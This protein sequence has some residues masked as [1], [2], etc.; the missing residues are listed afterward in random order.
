MD[1]LLARHLGLGRV[2]RPQHI[3]VETDNPA[4]GLYSLMVYGSATRD[5]VQTDMV[6]TSQG[7]RGCVMLVTD[8][9]DSVMMYNTYQQNSF[10]VM[11]KS[12]DLDPVGATRLFPVPG[13]SSNFVLYVKPGCVLTL[14]PPPGEVSNVLFY[15]WSACTNAYHPP[16]PPEPP[17]CCR[18]SPA[19]CPSPRTASRRG[20]ATARS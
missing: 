8:T 13:R 3:V 14:E 19:A 15:P 7:D 11:G 5:G 18:R 17:P 9:S 12:T 16:P 2:H 1:P 6:S 20:T 10:V 4:A